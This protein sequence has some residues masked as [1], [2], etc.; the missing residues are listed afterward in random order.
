MLLTDD[1]NT[2]GLWAHLFP[3]TQTENSV[4]EVD[5]SVHE[6]FFFVQPWRTENRV[7]L[8]YISVRT[9][10]RMENNINSSI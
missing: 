5:N 4:H 8:A 9:E 10:P 3:F 7:R 1:M 2:Q 6:V